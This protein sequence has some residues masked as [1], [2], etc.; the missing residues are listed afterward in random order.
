VLKENSEL[1]A[2]QAMAWLRRSDFLWRSSV[3][4]VSLFGHD[5]STQA[6]KH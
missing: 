3:W 6:F 5:P 2:Q 1:S 4:R